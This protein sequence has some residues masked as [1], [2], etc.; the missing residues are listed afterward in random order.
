M[1]PTYPAKP[2]LCNFVTLTLFGD[3]HFIMQCSALSAVKTQY[4]YYTK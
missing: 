4:M 2:F 1:H 3:L